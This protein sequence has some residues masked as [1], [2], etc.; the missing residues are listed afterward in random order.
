M[1]RRS[2]G[3]RCRLRRLP[4]QPGGYLTARRYERALYDCAKALDSAGFASFFGHCY[5]VDAKHEITSKDVRTD[6]NA[7]VFVHRMQ[8]R[9]AG[10]ACPRLQNVWRKV[11]SQTIPSFS[12]LPQLN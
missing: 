11:G 12:T 2:P 3:K 8:K 6:S 7:S 1:H 9:W 5:D 10:K 4:L